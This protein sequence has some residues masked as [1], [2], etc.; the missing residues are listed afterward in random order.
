MRVVLMR[1]CALPILARSN[2]HGN[3]GSE[4]FFICMIIVIPD[5]CC[6]C[7]IIIQQIEET[8]LPRTYTAPMK[9]LFS[10]VAKT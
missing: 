1:E 2:L 5:M 6:T 8:A 4:G 3:L 7:E 9:S 10:I